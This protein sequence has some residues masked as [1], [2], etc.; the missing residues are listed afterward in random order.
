MIWCKP[1]KISLN[2][3]NSFL[4]K[5]SHLIVGWI[6]YLQFTIRKLV[7]DI[8]V[9]LPFGEPSKKPWNDK[10]LNQDNDFSK[11]CV[12]NITLNPPNLNPKF[13]ILPKMRGFKITFLNIC[14]LTCHY[15]ELCVFME[16]K[17]I[18]ILG[19]N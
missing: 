14:S 4:Y 17:T 3:F 16:D 1:K 11:N 6:C 7:P 19:L 8:A 15:D 13:P 2:F 5:F 18:D 10:S 9:S 12:N